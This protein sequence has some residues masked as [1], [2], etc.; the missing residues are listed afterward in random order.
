MTTQ[1]GASFLK[2]V[3]EVESKQRGVEAPKNNIKNEETSLRMNLRRADKMDLKKS[4][5]FPRK[6]FRISI[7]R[8]KNIRKFS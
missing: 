3:R 7:L 2:V 8:A 6:F 5:S 1:K 4:F